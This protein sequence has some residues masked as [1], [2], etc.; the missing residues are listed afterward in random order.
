MYTFAYESSVSTRTPRLTIDICLNLGPAMFVMMTQAVQR[1]FSCYGRSLEGG[2]ES[3]FNS[4]SE[5]LVPWKA[6]KGAQLPCN[7]VHTRG[8]AESVM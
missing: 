2:C 7:Y 4:L 5:I 1:Q 8:S 3:N 6:A